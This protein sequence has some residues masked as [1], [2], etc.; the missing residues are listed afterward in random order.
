MVTMS[1]LTFEDS[2]RRVKPDLSRKYSQNWVLRV[3]RSTF[4]A[5]SGRWKT[6]THNEKTDFKTPSLEV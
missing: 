2:L 1:M 4:Y 5:A 3:I 6:S